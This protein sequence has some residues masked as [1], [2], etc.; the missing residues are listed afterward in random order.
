MTVVGFVTGILGLASSSSTV[1]IISAIAGT[2][3]ILT[4]GRSVYE[5]VLRANWFKYATLVLGTGYPYGLTDKFTYYTEY[6]Y[7]GTGIKNI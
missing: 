2:G 4:M 5:Y 6:I 1:A 7:T 3:G